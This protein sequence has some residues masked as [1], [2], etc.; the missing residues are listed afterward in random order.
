MDFSL[1]ALQLRRQME[2]EQE[3]NIRHELDN[4]FA[5]LRDLLYA[6]DP[7]LTG[8]N[9]IPLGKPQEVGEQP[10]DPDAAILSRV[11][12]TQDVG[13]D[14]HVRELAFDKRSKPKDRTKTEEELALEEKEA[15]EKAEEQRRKRMLGLEDSNSE[16]EGESRGKRKRGGDDLE[17]DFYDGEGD[18]WGGLGA[19]LSVKDDDR[20]ESGSEEGEGEEEGSEDDEESGGGDEGSD[21]GYDFGEEEGGFEDEE[22]EQENLTTKT[23][24]GKNRAAPSMKELPYT[25][26]APANHEEF[27]EIVEDVEDKD[28]P[29]VVQRIRTLYHTSLAPDNKFKLQVGSHVTDTVY[30]ADMRTDPRQ[31]PDR[32]HSLCC[33]APDTPVLP[34]FIPASPSHRHRQSISHPCRPVFQ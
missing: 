31:Y 12:E 5:A 14:Q 20:L 4:D 16:D 3:E 22:G 27:L 29:I 10:T 7:S 28:V 32:P 19:G 15:L 11:P 34:C 23:S 33:R 26:P 21:E 24:K 9:A 13:Y 30:P 2:K 1:T 18:E 8:S 6:P 25:F 17:D